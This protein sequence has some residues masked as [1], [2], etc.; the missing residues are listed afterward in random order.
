MRKMNNVSKIVDEAL[1]KDK[2]LRFHYENV[3]KNKSA[4]RYVRPVEVIRG[5]VLVAIDAA[6]DE[7]RR[8]RYDHMSDV[9]IVE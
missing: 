5:D 9:A 6:S 4:E 3:N 8:F 7:Y 1:V 2:S